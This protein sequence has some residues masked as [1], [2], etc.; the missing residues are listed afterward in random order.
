[1]S[2]VINPNQ[3]GP[4]GNAGP[5]GTQG[6]Q[7]PQGVKGDTGS[8]GPQGLKGDTGATGATGAT[9]TNGTN[10]ATG[11]TGPKGD[12]GDTGAQGIQGVQGVQGN[13]GAQGP[14][15]F[16]TVAPSTPARTLNTN[17]TPNATKA[18]FCSYSIR[19]QV[20]N[21]LLIGTSTATVTLLSDTNATPT[22]ARCQVGAESGVGITVTIALTT[23]NIAT[24]SYI[25]PAGHNVR[26]TSA[27]T[28]T[29]SVSIVSQVEEALG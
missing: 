27:T 2:G 24:L 17:F 20:T 23:A 21:P 15:G 14:A 9:G 22:T 4:K 6:S 18:T 16:G 29:G 7:G 8:Q 12:K 11:A 25:V 1:M 10:G 3:K 28:G 26:L 5:Q 19:T 13:T